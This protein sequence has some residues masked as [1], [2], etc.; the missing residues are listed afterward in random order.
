[1]T[2]PLLPYKVSYIIP[3][4]AKMVAETPMVSNKVLCQILEPYG[5]ERIVSRM[6]SYRVQGLKHGS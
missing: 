3:L 2:R 1:M 4:I 6:Q 5:V